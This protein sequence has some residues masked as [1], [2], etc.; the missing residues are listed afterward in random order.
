MLL[1]LHGADVIKIEPP[2]GDWGRVLGRTQENNTVHFV[3]FNR[4]KRSIGIDLAKTE[5]RQ[6]AGDLMASADVV[7]ESFRPGVA[8]RLGVD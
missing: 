7:I 8:A 1:A 2:E 4:G 6:I 5:G 3:A